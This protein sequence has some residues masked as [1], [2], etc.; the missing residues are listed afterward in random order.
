MK[1]SNLKCA[2][3]LSAGMLICSANASATLLD[4]TARV[5]GIQPFGAPASATYG[6][7]FTVGADNILNGFSLYLDAY[8]EGEGST[9]DVRGYVASWDGSKVNSILYTSTTRTIAATDT[10]VEFAFDT[11]ALVL[12]PGAQYLLFLSASG[13]GPQA[14]LSFIMP[15]TGPTYAGGQFMYVNSGMDLSRVFADEWNPLGVY[16]TD[17]AFKALLSQA[18][19]ANPVPEP[20]SLALLG[21]GLMGLAGWRRKR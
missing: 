1:W 20:A 12:S 7:T 5:G 19:H 4:N 14:P 17:I 18:N 3:L 9:L 11:G 8:Y 10:N 13:L 6:Q 16:D 15:H 21:L 2:A